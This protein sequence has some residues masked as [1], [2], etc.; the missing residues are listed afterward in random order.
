MNS[1]YIL[2]LVHAPSVK[3]FAVALENDGTAIKLNIQYDAQQ[4]INIG[5]KDRFDFAFVAANPNP[6]S[7]FL[8]ANVVTDANVPHRSTLDNKVSICFVLKSGKTGET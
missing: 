5:L 1:H 8:C 3:W 7:E 2:P 6:T 4:Q